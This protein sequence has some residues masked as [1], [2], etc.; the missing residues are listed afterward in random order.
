M[1]ADGVGVRVALAAG[2][3]ISD[4]VAAS[5]ATLGLAPHQRLRLIHGGRDIVDAADPAAPLESVGV[6]DGSSLLC[7]VSSF[8]DQPQPPSP[9]Q[10]ANERAADRGGGPAM[11]TF[12]ANGGEYGAEKD[13]YFGFAVG[14]LLGV[15][16]VFWLAVPGAMSLRHKIGVVVGVALNISLSFLRSV[17]P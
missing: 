11:V 1:Q 5:R 15:V 4:L 6:H 17:M 2:S 8:N 7:H 10:A 13:I 14:L 12:A 9:S 3:L 16:A